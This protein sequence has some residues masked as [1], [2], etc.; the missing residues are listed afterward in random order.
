MRPI[1]RS[2]VTD[3]LRA[4]VAI[5]SVN[6][7][8]VPGAPGEGEIARYL[9]GVCTQLGLDAHLQEVAPGR[10]NVI[11][12]LAG[13]GRGPRLLLNGH[14]DT[15]AA[16]GMDHPFEPMIRAEKLYG[17][18][19]YDMK[20]SIAA[21]LG[22]IQAIQA[23]GGR[24]AGDVIL[25]MVADE[26][27]ASLGTEALVAEVQADAA[28]VTEPT[29]L[30]VCIAHKG[31]AWVRFET[32]GRAAHGSRYD[33]GR[34]AIAAM[35]RILV[36]LVG[37][38][39]DVYPRRT[40]PLLG[41]PSVHAS[42]IGGGEGLSTY[43]PTCRLEVER[44]MLPEETAADVT[45]EMAGVVQRAVGDRG[46]AGTSEVFFFRPGYEI[47]PN[48]AIVETL[49][50]AAQRVLGSSPPMVGSWPWMDSA[51]LGR[52]GTPTVIFGP[53]GAGAHSTEEYVDLNSVMRCAQ[54]LA[55]AVVAFCGST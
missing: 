31:F 49:V 1:D 44:R 14:I 20:G 46:I 6:P 52:A 15:V 42:I 41:R 55:E 48:A 2:Y 35:G 53:G 23:T 25:T 11:A 18:G 13:R 34:D 50:T 16:T 43:P 36:E 17:R 4:L 10:Y 32:T 8:L 29:G 19:A 5:N 38:E 9:V 45:A 51:I 30:D 37:L 54:V 22:A 26:E 21:M 27:Y 33:E 3:L 7:S 40:H 12:I 28:I 39:A 47:S 24:L